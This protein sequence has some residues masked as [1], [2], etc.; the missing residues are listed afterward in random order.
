MQNKLYDEVKDTLKNITLSCPGALSVCSIKWPVTGYQWQ[1]TKSKG[2][3]QLAHRWYQ[4]PK[5]HC[6]QDDQKKQG[7]VKKKNWKFEREVK[8]M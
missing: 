5:L 4:V 1:A 3:T 2:H 8:T 7:W 6:L